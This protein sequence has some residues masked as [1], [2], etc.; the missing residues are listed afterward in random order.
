MSKLS[1]KAVKNLK[2]NMDKV[3]ADETGT[4]G[5]LMD[6]HHKSKQKHKGKVAT[7]ANVINEVKNQEGAFDAKK[8]EEKPTDQ[9][10]VII[11]QEDL[12]T[13]VQTREEKAAAEAIR[14]TEEFQ[15][16]I[17][18]WASHTDEVADYDAFEFEYDDYLVR[19]FKMDITGFGF[20]E[21]EHYIANLQG[22]NVALREKKATEGI[23]PIVKVLKV[24]RTATAGWEVGDILTVP[25]RDIHG[26]QLSPEFQQFMQHQNSQGMKP[27]IPEGY[28]QFVPNVEVNWKGYA[29]IRPWMVEPQ[30]IDY[31][32]FLLP[33]P[34]LRGRYNVK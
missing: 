26:Q 5:T 24:G 11:T 1:S 8:E 20:R 22:G 15:R 13:E 23:F 14:Y 31:I 7:A 34:K 10:G 33:S 4:L 32:T 29:F 9:E 6:I 30:E 17:S 21:Y 3:M 2:E 28:R 27:I 19:L 16:Q 18:E 25:S 12:D